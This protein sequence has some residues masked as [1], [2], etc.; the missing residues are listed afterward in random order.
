MT[1]AKTGVYELTDKVQTPGQEPGLVICVAASFSAVRIYSGSLCGL[2]A[3]SS[4]QIK[5]KTSKDCFF[6]STLE[7][8]EYFHLRS[9]ST[10]RTIK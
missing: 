7:E 4:D 10:Q 8:E 6:L 1:A 5:L 9:I 2:L 3:G